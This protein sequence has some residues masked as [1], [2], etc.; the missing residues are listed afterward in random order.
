MHGKFQYDNW[1]CHR[2][3]ITTS[4]RMQP[5]N[6]GWKPSTMY[7]FEKMC[8]LAVSERAE[9]ITLFVHPIG[10]L[11]SFCFEIMVP[12]M[13]FLKPENHIFQWIEMLRKILWR[14]LTT[15]I[16]VCN[17]MS[18]VYILT[19]LIFT[20]VSNKD[21]VLMCLLNPYI[22]PCAKPGRKHYC[23]TLTLIN[24]LKTFSRV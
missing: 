6:K 21:I 20:R 3:V 12:L 11:L 1:F 9:I 10:I 2:L 18:F 5:L 13:N 15:H 23:N 4:S 22:M 19:S 7:L 8:M 17:K 16:S 14:Q 24:L